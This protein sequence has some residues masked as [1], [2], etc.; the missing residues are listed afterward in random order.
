MVNGTIQAMGLA[1][2]GK[3][4]VTTSLQ[5]VKDNLAGLLSAGHIKNPDLL[6]SVTEDVSFATNEINAVLD[7]VSKYQP[8]PA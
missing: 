3:A 6:Q 8:A 4:T 1:G 7:V 5:A 2:T